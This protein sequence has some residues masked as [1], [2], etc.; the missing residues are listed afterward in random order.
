[1]HYLKS[2][3]AIVHS[4]PTRTWRELFSQRVRWAS[5]ASAY[6]SV[7]GKD[8]AVIVFAGNLAL[9]VGC[10]LAVGGSRLS[11]FGWSPWV[12][13]GVMFL[14]KFVVDTILLYKTNR[15][16][17]KKRLWFVVTSSVLYPFFC[18]TVAVFSWF[19]KYEWKGRKF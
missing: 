6:D 18:V 1:V 8:L 12:S 16:L 13:V 11:V 14:M 4:K 2:K 7:F 5:K 15:F 9:V 3:A 17:R 19:G 10:G